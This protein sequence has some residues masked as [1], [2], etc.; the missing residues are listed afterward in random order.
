MAQLQGNLAGASG[1]QLQAAALNNNLVNYNTVNGSNK[2]SKLKLNYD[3]LKKFLIKEQNSAQ[4]QQLLQQHASLGHLNQMNSQSQSNF[5]ALANQ[6]GPL[7]VGGLVQNPDGGRGR[8]QP[9]S[10]SKKMPAQSQS[11][12]SAIQSIQNQ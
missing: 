7:E 4:V 9:G 3:D 2:N 8:S 5:A 6:L 1:N 11:Q 10:K 12:L